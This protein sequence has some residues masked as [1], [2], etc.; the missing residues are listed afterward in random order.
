[1]WGG[2]CP[3]IVRNSH[4]LLDQPQVYQTTSCIDA[5]FR[6]LQPQVLGQDIARRTSRF[7]VGHCPP[8]IYPHVYLTSCTWLFLPGLPPRFCILQA[9]KSWRQEWP[10][11]E[12]NRYP[13]HVWERWEWGN[14]PW[15]RGWADT[16]VHGMCTLVEMLWL[17]AMTDCTGF[18]SLFA[19]NL[20]Y[21]A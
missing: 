19:F 2:Q 16:P 3:I 12:A 18:S 1:M 11:N 17:H 14:D 4:T 5:V 15:D 6:M 20:I 9:I 8:H 10:G 7:F 21:Y 13:F